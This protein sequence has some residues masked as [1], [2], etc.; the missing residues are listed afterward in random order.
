VKNYTPIDYVCAG[1]VMLLVAV[2]TFGSTKNRGKDVPLND[3]HR[4]IYDATKGGRSRGETEL[5]CATCHG[6]SSIPLPKN[7]PPKEQCLLCHLLT[8]E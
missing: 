6:K 5:I 7:H 4:P 2:L 8:S 3:R 1:S